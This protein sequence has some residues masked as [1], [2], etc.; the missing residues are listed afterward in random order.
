MAGAEES[1]IRT[2][3]RVPD[4]PPDALGGRVGRLLRHAKAVH[5]TGVDPGRVD[6][7]AFYEAVQDGIGSPFRIGED[8]GSGAPTGERWISI[9][10]DPAMPDRYRHTSVAQP[11][12][13]DYAYTV[14][15]PE[16]AL[17]YCE[18]R[19]P[20]G[21]ESLF[22]DGDDVV[23]LL[24]ARD[25]GLLADL[26]AR[27]VHFFKGGR[28]KRDRILSAD[29]RGTLVSWL[30]TCVHPDQPPAVRDVAERFSAFILRHVEPS[31]HLVA[32]ALAPGDAVVWHDRRLLHGRAAFE[33]R[34][35]GDRLLWKSGIFLSR[36]AERA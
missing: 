14:D 23:R 27:D 10:Y 21:G 7:R 25:P 24:E 8:S 22:V 35:H 18:R 19:A 34:E 28:G 5:V 17:M 2:I 6:L 13:T 31:E 9:R 3:R 4:E 30:R 36:G 32:L 1:L 20:R 11:L 12:H 26:R 15:N 29:E 33:A 16:L